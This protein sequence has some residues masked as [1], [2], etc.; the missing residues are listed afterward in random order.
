[1]ASLRRFLATSNHPLVRAAKATYNGIGEVSLPTPGWMMK[2][3]L[4]G[5]VA[6]RSV[7]HF[8]RRVLVAEPLFK[9]YVRS[10][11]KG[12]KTGIFVHWIQGSGDIIL[13]DHVTFDGKSGIKFAARFAD[14][15]TLTV[16]DHTGISGGCI[17][18]I[19]KAVTIGK[20]CRLA[21]DI[22]I[23]DSNGHP[24]EPVARKEGAPPTD[25]SVRPVTI[26][27][28]VW[29]G[30]RAIIL[31]GVTIGEG[32]IVS[33]GAVVMSDIAPYTV[34]AGNPARKIGVVPRETT[35]APVP[36]PVAVPGR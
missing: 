11:G 25:E 27:D 20:H 6:G 35:D 4:W 12:L 10:H 9:A 30:R 18:T 31:P 17:I 21:S 13:G 28:N 19:G 2:P 32:S 16:G 15:P 36:A 14:R 8:G 5:Y 23:T 33:S 22:I 3:A 29:I 26:H 34:V 1:M 24:A 7:I